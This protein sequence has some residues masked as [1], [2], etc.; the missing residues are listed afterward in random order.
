MS[1]YNFFCVLAAVTLATAF[2]N[3][4]SRNPYLPLFSDLFFSIA[5][6]YLLL[7]SQF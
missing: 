1:T 2:F 3:Y 5:G 6:H 7:N 4:F